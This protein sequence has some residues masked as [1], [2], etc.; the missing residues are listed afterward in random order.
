MIENTPNDYNR[1]I[2]NLIKNQR[3]IMVERVKGDV[4]KYGL[5]ESR[6]F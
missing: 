3:S 1:T 4:S 2:Q 5:E 6:Y